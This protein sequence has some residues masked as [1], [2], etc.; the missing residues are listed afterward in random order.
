MC[1]GSAFIASNSSESFKVKKIFL[2]QQ[3]QTGITVKIQRQNE[4]SEIDPEINYDRE[5]VLFKATDY[6]GL[7]KTFSLTYD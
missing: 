5:N 4:T 6:M 3:S 2:T 1:F 7:K